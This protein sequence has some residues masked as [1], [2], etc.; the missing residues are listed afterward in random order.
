M[1]H[2]ENR[3]SFLIS[4]NLSPWWQTSSTVLENTAWVY[5]WCLH[6]P[7]CG[8]SSEWQQTP[9][10]CIWTNLGPK[11]DLKFWDS[12]NNLRNKLK[13]GSPLR[14]LWLTPLNKTYFNVVCSQAKHLYL[15]RATVA[16]SAFLLPRQLN[17]KLSSECQ[18][19][20]PGT[21][22]VTGRRELWKTAGIVHF[23]SWLCASKYLL[24]TVKIM[25]LWFTTEVSLG[26][27]AL[28]RVRLDIRLNYFNGKG[29][30]A[31]P[32]AAQSSGGRVTVPGRVKKAWWCGTW[33]HRLVV[34]WQ[35]CGKGS[36]PW[37]WR[38]F[39]P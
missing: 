9:A 24:Q 2:L 18:F 3:K 6:P 33:G 36:T 31:L 10:L 22:S 38:S 1:H 7:A 37:F 32:E 23:A 5:L 21:L 11:P 34:A 13:S 39:P 12:P 30:Q 26:Q 17:S 8:T 4:P 29:F 16:L 35:Y 15:L 14:I 19:N 28:W 20:N 27:D 25:H